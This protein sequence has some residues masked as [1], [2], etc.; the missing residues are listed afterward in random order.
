MRIVFAGT[1]EF[2]RVALQRLHAAG[3]DIPLV[4]T[5]P[6]R[7]AGRGL[8]LLA[9]P[10]KAFAQEHGLE[11]FQPA[12]LGARFAPEA[13]ALRE[14][15]LKIRPDALVVAA[16]G[17]L[18]PGWLLDLPRWGC[19][20]I[21]ASLLP[22]WRGAAPIQRAILA[23]DAETG[24]S[25]MQM[26]VGL[27]TGDLLLVR[28]LAIRDVDTAASL[29]DQLADLGAELA[30]QALQQRAAG[31]WTRSPQPAEG[32]TYARKIDKQEATIDWSAGSAQLLRHVNAFNPVPGAQTRLE[33]ETLKIWAAAPAD[34][35]ID[36][37]TRPGTVLGLEPQSIVVATGDGA[38]RLT[39]LQRAG[40]KRLAAGSFL[41]GH[42]VAPGLVLGV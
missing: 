40:G 11:L 5:Q 14:R 4:L 23:G 34:T 38:L 30:L 1:P 22:R 31:T 42:P 41:R 28:R 3:V 35:A 29:H 20:N 15:L 39:E 16:Y 10:V 18:L 25:I 21:H 36:A 32:V 12:G 2:A 37:S 27:D 19:I 8:R 17:L 7:P 13:Q 33:G 26:D 6:D 9:S 24:I